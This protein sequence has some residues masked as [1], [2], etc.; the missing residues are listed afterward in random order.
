MGS[1]TGSIVVELF[2]DSD[3]PYGIFR[4]FEFH[5]GREGSG[6]LVRCEKGFRFDGASIPWMFRW[7]LSPSDPEL[8]QC[9]AGHDK[10]FRTGTQIVRDADG[11]EREEPIHRDTANA[12]MSEMMIALKVKKW[13]RQLINPA[14]AIGSGPAWRKNAAI[15]DSLRTETTR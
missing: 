13:K 4:E 2:P 1:F 6:V 11:T 5:A 15:R 9:A 7:L 14:L 8:L 10:L 12:Y 3:L